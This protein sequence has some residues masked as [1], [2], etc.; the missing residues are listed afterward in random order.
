M[1]TRSVEGQEVTWSDLRDQTAAQLSDRQAA[2]W[3]IEEVSGQRQADLLTDG[4]GPS[5]RARL[6]LAEMVRRRLEGE[7]LQ[8]VLGRWAFR[9]LDLMV[10]PRVLIPR[11]ETEQVVEIA[12]RELDRMDARTVLDLGTGTGA[13][14]L[15]VAA[16]RQQVQVWATDTQPTALD[17]ARANLAGMGGAAAT[18]V[19]VVRANWWDGLPEQLKK[20]IDLVVSNPPYI[21]AGEL[22]TLEPAVRDWEPTTALVAGETGTEAIEAI[23]RGAPSWIR[24][25]GAAV[26]E[27][28]PHQRAQARA[29]AAAAGFAEVGIE[30]DL[31]GRARALVARGAQ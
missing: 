10:D 3:M 16:E 20:R 12:L 8:Y 26:L 15:S 25:G 31:S 4:P 6:R 18:R 9:T 7:P 24:T 13:I 5:E 14:A 27:I 11:P 17:V 30:A 1:S 21:A 2:R 22:E 29:W 28:A 19:R 23:L